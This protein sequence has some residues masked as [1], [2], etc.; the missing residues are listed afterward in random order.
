LEE[1]LKERLVD[2]VKQCQ[3]Q[4]ETMFQATSSSNT[5]PAAFGN[6]DS[7]PDRTAPTSV[8]SNEH[9]FSITSPEDG[10]L[11][12]TA[13]TGISDPSYDS[14]WLPATWTPD[15]SVFEEEV[16][17]QASTVDDPSTWSFTEPFPGMSSVL[18]NNSVDELQGRLT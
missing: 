18:W 9:T 5:F 14:I 3:T 6:F 12:T 13:I 11:A 7:L 17:V 16:L 8:L 1:K 10:T 2:I 4:L 15:L